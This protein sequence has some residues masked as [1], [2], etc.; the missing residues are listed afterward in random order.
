MNKVNRLKISATKIMIISLKCLE[1]PMREDQEY[2]QLIQI[3]VKFGLKMKKE[4]ILQ[5]MQTG[6]QLK[7]CQLVLILTR[8]QKVLNIKNLILQEFKMENLLKINA[9]FCLHQNQWLILVYSLL[10]M[11]DLELSFSI[12]LNFSICSVLIKKKLI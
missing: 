2:T 8:W 7:K 1:F 4:I 5:Y 12:S 3:L 6:I 10:K 11:M 9:N